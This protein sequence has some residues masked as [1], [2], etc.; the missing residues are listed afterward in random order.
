MAAITEM[1]PRLGVAPTCAALGVSTASYYRRRKPK[2]AAIAARPSPPRTL[3]AAERSAVLAILHEPRFVDLAPAQVYAG[4]L[5]DQCYVCAERTMYRILEENQE[6]RERRDQL[7]HPHYAAPE[8]LATAPNQVWSWDITKL[9][10]PAKWTYF[11]LY[12][13][14]DIFSRYVVGWMI[15]HHESAALAKQLIEQ[16]CARQGIRPGQLTLHADRGASMKSKPVALLLSDLGV[17]KTHSRP[18]VSNDNP[19]SEAQFK[20]LKYRPEFPE[21]FGSIQ[22]ARGFGH[23][24]FPWY[25]TEHHHSGIGLLTP[26]DVHFGRAAGRVAARAEV[27]ALAYAA[28]P[29]R[30][31]RGMP[32]PAPVPTAVWIN[33]PKPPPAARNEKTDLVGSPQS[34]DLDPGE[35]MG[36]PKNSTFAA[37]IT[38]S[39]LRALH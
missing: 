32:H 12:V 4:L 34:H 14:L 23:V 17:T 7:R 25:N 6:V 13:I 27:L 39:S 5:D 19:F 8:L 20:T 28:H 11:S 37:P 16:S 9:L 36:T 1:G 31:V 29:E 15:A 22:D 35:D 2:A 18:Y 33:P 24:F 3:P 30:F 21:H 26:A 38:L 10:G